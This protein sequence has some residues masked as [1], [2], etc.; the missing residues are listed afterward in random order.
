MLS[1]PPFL[2]NPRLL[3]QRR[4]LRAILTTRTALSAGPPLATRP[5]GTTLTASAGAAAGTSVAG[6]LTA[7]G[8]AVF[9]RGNFP[10]AILVELLQRLTGLGDFAGI[11]NAIAVQIQG[12]H[13]R[14]D[15]TL[16]A[17]TALAGTAP[18][19]ILVGWRKLTFTTLT[20][21]AVETARRATLPRTA[22]AG[23]AR[24]SRS[25]TAPGAILVGRR[26]LTF[27]TLT[28]GPAE[29]ARR[30]TLPRTALASGAAPASRA[31][32]LLQH[33]ELVGF[34]DFFQ[35][36]LQFR[37]QR[38]HFL[39]LGFR[40]VQF[41][42][43]WRGEDMEAAGTARATAA[44]G[45]GGLV[46]GRGIAVLGLAEA[47]R[48]PKGQCEEEYF[49]FHVVLIFCVIDRVIAKLFD[50]FYRDSPAPPFAFAS[51]Q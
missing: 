23:S 47:G 43:D 1:P 50:V 22:M 32:E 33:F 18:G 24:D 38:R 21:G 44:A 37:L 17:G 7:A 49:C 42:H 15:R 31:H 28:P 29:T 10:V 16:S 41:V 11:N 20:P 13:Q 26:K 51:R 19:A 30:A 6:T 40:Q 8:W 14:V 5:T 35:F 12:G 45:A 34:E 4:S 2:F 46:N 48:G 27:T 36:T 9:L 39:Q 3:I 25:G